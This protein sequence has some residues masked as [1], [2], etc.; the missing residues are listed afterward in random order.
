VLAEVQLCRLTKSVVYKT[1]KTW[2]RPALLVVIQPSRGPASAQNDDL[3][4]A[5]VKFGYV[6]LNRGCAMENE[7]GSSR[8]DTIIST[9]KCK[10]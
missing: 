6:N 1:D 8:A 4:N 9:R 5:P 2:G 7:R 10:S 3:M